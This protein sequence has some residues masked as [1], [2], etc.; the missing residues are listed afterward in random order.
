MLEICG[1]TVNPHKK[2]NAEDFQVLKVIGKGGYG[3]VSHPILLLAIGVSRS[4]NNQKS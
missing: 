3:T 2:V 1:D 4:K